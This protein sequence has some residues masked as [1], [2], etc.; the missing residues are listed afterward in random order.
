MKLIYGAAIKRALRDVSPISVAV[1]YVGIDWS[2]YIETSTLKEIVLSP[3]IGSNP[4]AIVQLV[5][6]LG[7]EN[8]YFLDNLHSKVYIGATQAAVGSFNLT[9]NG[10]SAVGLHEAGYLISEPEELDKLKALVGEYKALAAAAYPTE[11]LKSERLTELRALWDRAIKTGAIRNDSTSGNVLDYV[12]TLG[13]PD[14]YVCCTW[15][16]TTYS[17]Q[18][19]SPST[20]N[21]S[22]SFL[23][24]DEIKPDRWILCWSAREDGYPNKRYDPYWLHIDEVVKNGAIDTQYTRIAIE[25]NDRLFLNYPFEL[26]PPTV[27][28]LRVVLSSGEF[29]EFLGDKEPWSVNDT[30]PRLPEFFE[31]VRQSLRTDILNTAS[32]SGMPEP[33]T[34]EKALRQLFKSRVE[35]ATDLAVE[36]GYVKRTIHNMLQDTHAVELAKKLVIAPDLKSGLKQLK[37][38]NALDLS[39]ECIMLEPQFSPLFSKEQL[40]CAQWNLE[41]V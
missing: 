27:E 23:D 37:K 1:A 30:L 5:A 39:F 31:K 8:I 17:D 33:L 24:I 15:G 21:Q 38:A 40:E 16:D 20:I 18:V 25:R 9:A 7:W 3:T 29:P 4:V 2:T 28:A 36:K 14:V 12:P 6:K 41:R 32:G 19:V 10:L 35:T 22:L 26:T 11:F 34:N 13:D